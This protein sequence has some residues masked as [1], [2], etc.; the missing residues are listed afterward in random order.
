VKSV[1]LTGF[2]EIHF[3]G[4]KQVTGFVKLDMICPEHLIKGDPSQCETK[5]FNEAQKVDNGVDADSIA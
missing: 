4:K 1:G 3:L 5:V 2:Q